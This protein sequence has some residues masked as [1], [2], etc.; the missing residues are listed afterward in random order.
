MG[1]LGGLGASGRHWGHREPGPGDF[2]VL[3]F[4]LKSGLWEMGFIYN[5]FKKI[6]FEV[7]GVR[8]V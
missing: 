3:G 7:G 8:W 1:Y 2:G 6:F 5:F 4:S